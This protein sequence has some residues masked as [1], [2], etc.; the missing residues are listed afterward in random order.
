MGPSP[1]ILASMTVVTEKGETSAIKKFFLAVRKLH[2][3]CN[4]IAIK[5]ITPACN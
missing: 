5:S 2:P 4:S 3:Y 1:I